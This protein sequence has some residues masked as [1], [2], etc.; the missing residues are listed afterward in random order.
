MEKKTYQQPVTD[1]VRLSHHL[2]QDIGY[3]GGTVSGGNDDVINP[4][5]EGFF[6]DLEDMAP[7][8]SANNLWDE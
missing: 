6:D 4:A 8:Q 2:L 5:N 1:I 7:P 3:E